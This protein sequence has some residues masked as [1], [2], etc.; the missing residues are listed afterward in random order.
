[1]FV[2]NS[3]KKTLFHYCWRFLLLRGRENNEKSIKIIEKNNNW[4]P[5]ES[6]ESAVDNLLCFSSRARKIPTHST[7]HTIE[8]VDRNLIIAHEWA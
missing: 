8:S 6:L 2:E 4:R 3:Q 1:M 7:R 5:L